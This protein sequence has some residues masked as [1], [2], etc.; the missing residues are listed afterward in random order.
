M[1]V[2]LL[3]DEPEA[4]GLLALMQLHEARRSARYGPAGE[5][6]PLDEQDRS[7]W[8]R[9]RIDAAMAIL[10]WAIA[11]RRRG[12]YQLQAAIAALHATAQVEAETDWRQV[13]LLYEALARIAGTPVVALNHAAAVA[14]V[15]GP[16][17]GLALLEPLAVELLSQSSASWQFRPA[18]R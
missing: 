6:I 17:V 18:W 16:E 14:M 13:V 15:E 8:D 11:L 10:D 1:L 7:R 4:L 2:E 3:P 12:P 9:E 5:F